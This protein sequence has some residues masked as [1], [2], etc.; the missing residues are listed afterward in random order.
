LDY[1]TPRIV[2]MD[3]AVAKQWK[4]KKDLRTINDILGE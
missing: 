3:G 2:K 1:F 4:K